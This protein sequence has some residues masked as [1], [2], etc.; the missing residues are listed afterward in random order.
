MKIDARKK[1][2]NVKRPIYRSLTIVIG[3]YLTL[4]FLITDIERLQRSESNEYNLIYSND[5]F[6]FLK[7]IDLIEWQ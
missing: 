4:T 2:V 5:R 1:V 3:I 7:L 6:V